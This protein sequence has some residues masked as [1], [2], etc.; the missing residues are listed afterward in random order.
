MVQNDIELA[1]YNMIEQQVRPWDVLDERVLAVMR[2]VPR[3]NFVP[4]ACRDLAFADTEI[5]IGHGEVMMKPNLEGRALQALR[6]RGGERVLEIGTGSGYVT[7]C[8]A[9]LAGHVDSVDIEPDFTQQ[10]SERLAAL[11]IYN[12]S[13]TTGDVMQG[14]NHGEY[15]AILVT[16]S[17]PL[18]PQDLPQRLAVG[19]RLF[20][21]VGESPVME[22]MRI[23][24]VAEDAWTREALFETELP[25]LRN[26]PCSGRFVF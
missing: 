3:E 13:L 19:G 2:E 15:D 18:E 6:L 10:A 25:P 21:V 4:D 11:G 16:G 26:V 14:M 20:V 22:A 5:P 17:M 7:A 12:V 9:R 8:L 23:T 1:R 24:R